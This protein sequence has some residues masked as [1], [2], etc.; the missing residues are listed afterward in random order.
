MES[1]KNFSQFFRETVMPAEGSGHD[2]DVFHFFRQSWSYSCHGS[3]AELV[4]NLVY[5][6][7]NVVKRNTGL[8]SVDVNRKLFNGVASYLFSRGARI[9]IWKQDEAGKWSKG[10]IISS[11]NRVDLESE[12]G[13]ICSDV[14]ITPTLL[15]IYACPHTY[16]AGV[17]LWSTSF[18]TLKVYDFV[19]NTQWSR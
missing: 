10:G 9:V 14:S 19:D 2:S 17:C 5:K 12:I 13:D 1:P 8:A 6:T 18:G 3:Q 4:A 15:A 11:S 16:R 7:L